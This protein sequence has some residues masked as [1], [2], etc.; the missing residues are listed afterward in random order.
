MLS[1]RSKLTTQIKAAIAILSACR[2][3][4]AELRN[5]LGQV[6]ITIATLW[7]LIRFVSWLL[8]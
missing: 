2:D 1:R 4:L 5:F 6:V 8:R 3:L 7:G